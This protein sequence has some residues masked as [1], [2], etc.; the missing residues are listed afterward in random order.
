MLLN[1]RQ[2]KEQGKWKDRILLAI[3]DI[4]E[5]D[6]DA[7]EQEY[8]R[9]HDIEIAKEIE[10][11]ERK[12]RTLIKKST[13]AIQLLDKDAT[14]IFSSDSVDTVLGYTPDEIKHKNLFTFIHPNY[15]EEVKKQF[16]YILEE[17]SNQF[18][19]EYRACHKDGT[20]VWIEATAVNYLDNP[21]LEAI[22]VNFRNI[23]NRK[24]A[25]A[26]QFMLAAIV[27]SSEDAIV[28]KTLDGI[29]TSWNKG[30]EELFGYPA[31]E[32]IG[33]SINLIIP[34]E[35][36]PEEAEIIRKLKRGERIKHFETTRVRKDGR[37][38]SVSLSI[39]PMKDTKGV[40]VGAA[41]IARDIT[42]Q[43][44]LEQQK[45]E[46]LGIVSHELKTP[47]TSVKAYAQVL[48]QKFIRQGDHK[49]AEL[50]EKMD[51][52]LNKLTALIGDLLDATKIEAGQMKFNEQSFNIN[53]LVHEIVEEIQHTSH[54]HTI[55]EML[56]TPQV[57]TGDR[58]RIGQVITNL[59]TNAIKYS[60]HADKVHVGTELDQNGVKIYVKDYGIGLP[61]KAKDKVFERFYRVEGENY[62]TIAGLGLGLYIAK[63]IIERHKGEM[64]VESEEGVGS[65][66]WFQLPVNES[67]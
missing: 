39:S 32:A 66:F 48:R 36:R 46:F 63:E 60:P 12:F 26:S 30:A 53:T 47:V 37:R 15:I 64:G 19:I 57:I 13:D 24:I 44:E 31:E 17:P 9:K 38:I 55:I 65:T 33:Q 62:K 14:I 3:H 5:F 2:I 1:A 28:S 27:H 49:S 40:I 56:S 29:I 35:L 59:L 52:Q 20:W 51:M 41:K 67:I 50:L 23:T 10:R 54:S 22:V 25:E 7:I 8:K 16:C 18:A 34:N 42:Q 43:K 6:K 61:Q 21:D 11:R 4:T 58:D 45:D